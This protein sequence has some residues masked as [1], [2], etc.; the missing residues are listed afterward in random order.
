MDPLGLIKEDM[1][2]LQRA[3]GGQNLEGSGL[4]LA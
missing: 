3:L 2:R 1:R 4:G